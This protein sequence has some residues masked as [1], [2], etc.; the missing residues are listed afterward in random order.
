MPVPTP[1]P[2]S[3]LPTPSLLRARIGFILLIALAIVLGLFLSRSHRAGKSGSAATENDEES[4]RRGAAK[5]GAQIEGV[6]QI[7]T[8]GAAIEEK[9][10]LPPCWEG[11]MALDENPS[12]DDLRA[13]LLTA[14]DDPLLV[15]YLQARLAEAI[16][17]KSEAA[18]QVIGWATQASPPLVGQLLEAL[19]RAPAAQ[20]KGVAEKLLQLGEDDSRGHDLRRA[21]IDALDSQKS[22]GA[23][24]IARLKSVALDE[25]SDEVGWVATRTIGR[26][27]VEDYKQ[28]GRFDGYWRELLDV[29]QRSSETAVRSL[30]LEMPSYGD[31]PVE[32]DSIAKL[33]KILKQD[34]DRQVREM[35]AFRLG[36][37][38][39]PDKALQSFGEAFGGEKDLCVRWA[40]FRFA[41]RAAGEKALP[42]LQQ[43]S[44]VEPRLRPDY[45]DFRQI[46]ESGNVDFV[47]VWLS[48]PERHQCL[49]DAE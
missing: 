49:E 13:A 21:A 12:L 41:V 45:E 46:Y 28:G 24:S 4:T 44:S 14:G 18:L 32:S 25:Q 1:P 11:L 42:L 3:S 35:A 33:T 47:R 37:S 20:Q 7:P 16:A 39:E 10:P 17:D 9:I 23:A 34:P 19:K 43:L 40:I 48:K 29:G 6:G 15:E 2:P 8:G 38:R 5:N 27:M 26:V 30:A 36:L 31:I 22:L